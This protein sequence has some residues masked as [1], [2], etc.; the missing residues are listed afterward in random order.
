MEA[1]LPAFHLAV[2]CK[3]MEGEEL[4]CTIP[5]R[6]C[7]HTSP[8]PFTALSFALWLCRLGSVSCFASVIKVT[9]PVAQS[10]GE[11]DTLPQAFSTGTSTQLGSVPACPI[12]AL[13]DPAALQLLS[14]THC[15]PVKI[16]L[17]LLDGPQH[18]QCFL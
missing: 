6:P 10:L 5:D 13:S 12:Y 16:Q 8:V 17:M 2:L 7:P 3:R 14:H 1:A 15:A 9:P 11:A 4:S 18:S